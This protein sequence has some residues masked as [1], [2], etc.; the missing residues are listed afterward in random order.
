M[1]AS[2]AE[3]D[4]WSFVLRFSVLVVLFLSLVVVI[5]ADGG[6]EVIVRVYI[7]FQVL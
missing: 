5:V 2:A 7:I 4:N 6:E 1:Q 3:V